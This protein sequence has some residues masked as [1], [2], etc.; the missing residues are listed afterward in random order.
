MN[1]SVR[2]C[3]NE[4]DAEGLAGKVLLV[5]EVPVHRDECVECTLH[6][7]QKFTVLD[8]IPTKP[9]DSLGVMAAQEAGQVHGD[10]LVK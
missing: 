5:R 3:L 4:D 8:T 2:R 7:T 9:G 1:H 10:V 6:P